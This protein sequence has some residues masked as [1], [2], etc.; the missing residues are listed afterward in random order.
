MEK[1][2]TEAAALKLNLR[3]RSFEAASTNLQPQAKKAS[4]TNVNTFATF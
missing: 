3:L 2:L 1:Y 4:A